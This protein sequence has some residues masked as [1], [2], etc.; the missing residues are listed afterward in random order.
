MQQQ[1]Q[2][3]GYRRAVF[4]VVETLSQRPTLVAENRNDIVQHLLPAVTRC[5][6]G[7][8]LAGDP[9]YLLLALRI[10]GDLLSHSLQRASDLV[11]SAS[12]EN[13]PAFAFVAKVLLPKYSTLLG[14]SAPDPL[15]QLALKILCT[16]LD[17]NDAFVAELHR[18]RLVRRVVTCLTHHPPAPQ[19]AGATAANMSKGRGKSRSTVSGGDGSPPAESSVHAA[20]ALWY[21]L[22]WHGTSMLEL[23]RFDMVHRL[24][25]ATIVALRTNAAACFEP[26]LACTEA[27]LLHACKMVR[28]SLSEDGNETMVAVALA[29]PGAAASPLLNLKEVREYLR[30]LLRPDYVLTVVSLLA[31]PLGESAIAAEE[32]Q[33]RASQCVLLMGQFLGGEFYDML[34]DSKCLSLLERALIRRYDAALVGGVDAY[35]AVQRRAHVEGQGGGERRVQAC[36]R[37]LQLLVF[38]AD[39]DGREQYGRA[40]A[41][42]DGL[43]AALKKCE[44]SVDSRDLRTA[45]SG[46]W[47]GLSVSALAHVAIQKVRKFL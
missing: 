15:P 25:K 40:L 3:L 20:R 8:R 16:V 14:G 45:V 30:E 43:M 29:N 11:P 23:H 37:V 46:S 12:I 1:Q 34:I 36:M 9:D 28:G 2:R 5:F 7:T 21:I 47:A 13:D 39:M 4:L 31:D 38:A 27:V 19:P 32:V 6:E 10:I 22:S 44:G 24:G 33:L 17:R 18:T 26:L 35:G 41:G 42:H